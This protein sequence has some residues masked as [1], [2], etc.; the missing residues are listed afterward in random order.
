MNPADL[1]NLAKEDKD[2]L[3][4]LIETM[5]TRDR[6]ARAP[7]DARQAHATPGAAL[8]TW[9]CRATRLTHV[10]GVSCSLRM[11]NGLVERC[12]VSCVDSF[13][14][15]TLEKSEEQARAGKTHMCGVCGVVCAHVP[16]S[17]C[18]PAVRDQVLREVPE[19]QRARERAL[20]GAER[21]P[22][23]AQ[24]SGAQTAPPQA[25]L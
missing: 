17:A 24:V 19:A 2:E 10:C 18:L 15:K 9:R 6:R 21:R 7:R 16:L 1:D 14:R 13:R 23:T 12:F 4:G 3:L 20:R 8:A 5:Q 22:R 11:Y 25:Q